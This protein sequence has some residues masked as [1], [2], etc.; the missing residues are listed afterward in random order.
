MSISS[1][2]SVS[3]HLPPFLCLPASFSH[4]FPLPLHWLGDVAQRVPSS[5][6]FFAFSL[7]Y[8][9]LKQTARVLAEST[10]ASRAPLPLPREVNA[11]VTW[12]QLCSELKLC[13]RCGDLLGS[14]KTDCMLVELLTAGWLLGVEARSSRVEGAGVEAGAAFLGQRELEKSKE[15]RERDGCGVMVVWWEKDVK[16]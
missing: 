2:L 15:S 9:K 6:A 8:L 3:L 16:D 7:L 5:P 1:L 11:A 10:N 12:Q 4:H 14:L 13:G